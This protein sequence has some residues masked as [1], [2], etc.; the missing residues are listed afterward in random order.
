MSHLLAGDAKVTK[1]YFALKPDVLPKFLKNSYFRPCITCFNTPEE[2]LK[3]KD[4]EF[5]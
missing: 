3:P 4:F 1:R 5:Y 2:N